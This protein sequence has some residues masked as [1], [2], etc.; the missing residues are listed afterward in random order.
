MKNSPM[1]TEPSLDV[2]DFDDAA[3]L[4][5]AHSRYID[6]A[7]EARVVRKIDLFFIPSMILGYGLV[8]YDKVYTFMLE[9]I[10]LYHD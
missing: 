9:T 1:M 6:P 3:A 10:P 4:V 2:A 7:L 5:G 8:Y